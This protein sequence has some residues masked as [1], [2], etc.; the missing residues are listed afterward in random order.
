MLYIYTVLI[1][2][3]RMKP[4]TYSNQSRQ[5]HGILCIVFV[6]S[7]LIALGTQVP[8]LKPKCLVNSQDLGLSL[9]A[10]L[11]AKAYWLWFQKFKETVKLK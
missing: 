5:Q 7:E 10:R 11:T 2:S 4:N 9:S 1:S 3:I 6:A 8:R